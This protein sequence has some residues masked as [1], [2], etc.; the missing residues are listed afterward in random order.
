MDTSGD[1]EL[2][3]SEVMPSRPPPRRRA[4]WHEHDAIPTPS[5]S[6]S[7]NPNPEQAIRALRLDDELRD[8]DMMPPLAL[9][10][11]LSRSYAPSA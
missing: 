8:M 3:R 5:P 11:T 9:A 4:A 1:G 6:P 2:S 10:L 7:P